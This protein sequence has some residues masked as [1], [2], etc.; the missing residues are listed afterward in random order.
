MGRL[1]FHLCSSGAAID[2]ANVRLEWQPLLSAKNTRKQRTGRLL[3]ESFLGE[4]CKA[5]ICRFPVPSEI[6]TSDPH[7][8]PLL[9]LFPR[10]LR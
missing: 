6:L 5:I 2:N 8:S 1:I 4:D 7:P 9:A 3:R 10:S